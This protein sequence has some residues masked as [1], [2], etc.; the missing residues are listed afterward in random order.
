MVT[1]GYSAGVL[2]DCAGAASVLV[3]VAELLELPHAV[4]E[5]AK[6]SAIIIANALFTLIIVFLS[7]AYIVQIII[8]NFISICMFN[9]I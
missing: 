6:I 2:L 5:N 8:N 3:P 7:F 9:I 4:K 1:G